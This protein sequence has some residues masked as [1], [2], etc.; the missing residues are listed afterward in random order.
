MCLS[1]ALR[2]REQTGYSQSMVY[3]EQLFNIP[4]ER[5]TITISAWERAEQYGCDMSLLAD[6][7]LKTPTQ[8]IKAHQQALNTVTILRNALENKHARLGT[9]AGTSDPA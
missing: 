4:R 3:A 6:N 9:A 8:R 1:G 5:M 7:M 2:E